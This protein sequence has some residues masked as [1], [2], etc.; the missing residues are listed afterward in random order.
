MQAGALCPA[1]QA[2]PRPAE[3]GAVLE[4]V[5]LVLAVLEFDQYVEDPLARERPCSISR[6]YYPPVL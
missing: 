6:W 1:K 2:A 5:R 4:K 3:V